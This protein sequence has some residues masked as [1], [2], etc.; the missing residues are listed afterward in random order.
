[1]AENPKS[2][3]LKGRIRD[4]DLQLRTEYMQQRDFAFRGGGC[5][6]AGWPSSSRRRN[7]RPCC[8]ENSL[9]P[10]G[11]DSGLSVAADRRG[12]LGGCGACRGVAGGG[13]RLD[14][15]LSPLARGETGAGKGDSPR[16]TFGRCPV[17]RKSGQS[18]GCFHSAAGKKSVG[19]RDRQGVAAVSRAGRLGRRRPMKA[20]PMRGTPPPAEH[21]LE[22]ARPHAGQQLAG[23][24]GHSRFSL[25]GGPE[26]P[27]GRLLRRRR[28]QAAVARGTARGGRRRQAAQRGRRL[29]LADRGDRRPA[30][31]W[32]FCQRRRRGLRFR[33]PPPLGSQPR[34]PGQ[35]LRPRRLAGHIPRLAPRAHGS[36]PEREGGK[37]EDHGVGHGHGQ[38]GL[39]AETPRAQLLDLADRRPRRRPR[40]VDHRRR[41]VG[42]RLPT[43]P[44]G[45]NCGG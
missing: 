17:G 34:L 6:W 37:V 20:F 40:P 31:V 4:I 43:C 1:M 28:R 32:R 11:D 27:R 33:R 19:R 8:S 45:R 12:P 25:R 15:P 26:P 21:P 3:A 42:D 39:G 14:R 5:S 9:A 2:E 18:P 13:R 36:R 29:R 41:S 24:L 16:P 23:G 10:T 44:T 35:R 22:N 7:G 38:D 30:G